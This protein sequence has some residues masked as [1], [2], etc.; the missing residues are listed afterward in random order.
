[1]IMRTDYYFDSL[2]GGKIHACRWLP[3]GQIKA[4]VQIVHGIAE[5][6]ERYDDLASFLNEHGILV[7]AEDHMGH[8]KSIC[9]ATPMGCFS[10]GWQTAVKDTYRLLKN[11][12]AE[13]PSVPY[14]L[15]GHSMGSFMARTILARHP[16]SGIAGAIICGTAWMPNPVIGAGK[17]LASAICK[18]NGE[19]NPSGLLQKMMFGSYN[20]KVEHPRT[21]CDWLTRDQKIVDAYVADPLCGFVP[22]AGLVRE[23]MGGLQYIQNPKNLDVMNKDL[24]VFFIAGGDDPVGGYG[25]GV[26]KCAE[27]FRKHGM[28]CVDIKIYPLCRHEIHNEINKQEVYED[29]LNWISQVK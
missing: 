2:G 1:M 29:V 17:T 25:A 27:E 9:E 18:K 28:N 10:G 20:N 3:N 19:Q 12:M 7:V 5:Y 24:P 4:V 14:I 11:T 13:F 15:F 23:M 21:D 26:R 22:S 6:V 16:G 8:G